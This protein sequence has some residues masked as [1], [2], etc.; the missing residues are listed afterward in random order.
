MTNPHPTA[1]HADTGTHTDTGTRTDTM[2]DPRSE[3]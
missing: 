2:L 1:T 3:H